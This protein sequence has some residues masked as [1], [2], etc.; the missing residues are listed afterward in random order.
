MREDDIRQAIANLPPERFEHFARELVRR[1]LYP[2]LNPTT[3]SY[4]LGEDSRSE[5]STIFM[6]GGKWISLAISKTISLTKIRA[7]CNTIKANGRQIDI[8]V[9]VSSKD[10]KRTSTAEN[11]RKQIKSEFSWELEMRTLCWL[12]PVASQPKFESL[13]DDYL[14][15]PPPGG[16]YVQTIENEFTTHTER[17]LKQISN[18]IPGLPS[19]LQR[20]EISTIEEQLASRLP[21]L[22]TGEAGTGKSAIG[23]QL[24]HNGINAGKAVLLLDA[25]LIGHIT[26]RIILREHL[27]LRGPVHSAVLRIGK[28]KGCRLI[29]DQLDNIAGMPIADRVVDLVLDC[30]PDPDHVDIVVISRNQEKNER[31]LIS[32]LLSGNFVEIPCLPI[33]ET[34]VVNVFNQIGITNYTTETIELGRNLLNL[35]LIGK[36]QQQ[37]P[38]YDF[39]KLTSEVFLWEEY[40]DILIGDEESTVGEQILAEAICLAKHAL[41]TTEGTFG[42]PYP[43]LHT[44]QR[45]VSWGI[46]M[47]VEGRVHRF[48]H[49]RFQEYLYAWDATQRLV[50]PRQVISEITPYRS[51]NIFQWMNA[52]YLR[53]NSSMHERFL[54]EA[55]DV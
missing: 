4:D 16:D 22:L 40:M 42:L 8:L 33:S 28:Y 2:N 15:I 7:D 10:T 23:A 37:I 19:S 39:R 53:N 35:E 6:Q 55:L 18:K 12:V 24:A 17:A 41:S 36:I 27:G 47:P 9:F 26:T 21:V 34:T 29:I 54:R 32:R 11:W 5:P 14:Y 30:I 43:L 51:Q 3:D 44:Q 52:I 1:E 20:G 31:R 46:I 13:V 38:Y 45:M 50:L 48:R 25:R 49:E